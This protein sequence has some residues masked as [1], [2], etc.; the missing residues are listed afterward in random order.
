MSDHYY[1][2]H[3]YGMYLNT[4][5]ADKFITEFAK[6]NDLDKDYKYDIVNSI[7]G[8]E[9]N[10]DRYD[11]RGILAL[12]RNNSGIDNDFADGIFIYANKQG[13]IFNKLDVISDD[14]YSDIHEMSEEF[15]NDFGKYLP[16]EFNYE[17][18]M[19][20]FYGAAFC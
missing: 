2:E 1:G 8:T 19:V 7:S 11:G 4:D 3:G 10:D 12:D 17:A 18:H 9:L 15:R 5:E 14:T 6:Q 16:K 13:A 20:E